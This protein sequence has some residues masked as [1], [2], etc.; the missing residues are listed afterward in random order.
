MD[1]PTLIQSAER[2]LPTML[3]W[4]HRMVE[5]N[6][7]T[8]NIE[9][10]NRV[11]ALTAECFAELG[12]EAESVP[13][14]DPTH[15]SHLFLRRGPAEK[16]PIVL[17][18]HLDTVFPPEEEVRNDFRWLPEGNRIYGPGTVDIKGGT[19]LI[20]LMLRLLR[21][22]RPEVF[23]QT[24]WLIAANS[25]EEVIGADFSHRTH[26]RCPHGAR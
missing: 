10:V 16:K 3:D 13:S 19:T 26:E 12:F 11:G 22:A 14:N 24:H 15:G 23:E 5:I 2:S 21:E 17:V 18:T 6:S 25:A 8:T 4:L 1:I 9:G 20:W 7:F